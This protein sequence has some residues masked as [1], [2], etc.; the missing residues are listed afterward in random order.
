MHGGGASHATPMHDA[1]P[2]LYYATVAVKGASDIW[3]AVTEG[4]P[5]WTVAGHGRTLVM[6]GCTSWT[7]ARH[8]GHTS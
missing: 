2:S 1:P 6:A 7:E 5:S 3:N 4:C 8:D